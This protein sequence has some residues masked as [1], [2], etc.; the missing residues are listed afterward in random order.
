MKMPLLHFVMSNV[1]LM[2][3]ILIIVHLLLN[4]CLLFQILKAVARVHIF[5]NCSRSLH[6]PHF[7]AKL[8]LHLYQI[9]VIPI[10][11]LDVTVSEESNVAN[12][13]IIMWP[14]T[15][16][17][18]RLLIKI[19]KHLRRHCIMI[20]IIIS[21]FISDKKGIMW[22]S[23]T[24]LLVN[25]PFLNAVVRPDKRGCILRIIITSGC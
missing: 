9:F 15:L 7:N 24:I 2:L 10:S 17:L 20:I 8:L 1:L 21:Y 5:N 6:I 4:F 18:N 13:L 19:T 23:R 14:L 16:T 12:M 11:M 3:H 25:R 22:D